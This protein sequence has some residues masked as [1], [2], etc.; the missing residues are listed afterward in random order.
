M[1]LPRTA[2]VKGMAEHE[3][4]SGARARSL[5][6]F[7]DTAFFRLFEQIL[8]R[9]NPHRE[10]DTWTASGVTW[11]HTRHSFQAS[12]YGFAIEVFEATRGGK[13]GWTLLVIKEHWWAG[14]HGEVMRSTNWAKP[15]K[16]RRQAILT[17]FEQQRPELETAG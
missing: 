6:S 14:K 10:A 1:S 17:W 2:T 15:M 13:D 4:R 7:A 8:L 12:D 16:G 9:D 11:N 5:K 3:E